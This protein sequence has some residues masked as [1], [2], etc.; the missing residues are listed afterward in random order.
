MWKALLS[1]QLASGLSSACAGSG[2]ADST[3]G[4]LHEIKFQVLAPSTHKHVVFEWERLV[5]EGPTI[6]SNLE[7]GFEISSA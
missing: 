7:N 3:S 6:A 4:T 2:I 1:M 5:E